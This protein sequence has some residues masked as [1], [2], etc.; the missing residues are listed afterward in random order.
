MGE[1]DEESDAGNE[2]DD[3]QSN[4][5]DESEQADL[6]ANVPLLRYRVLKLIEQS[7]NQIH[8]YNN[9]I[10]SAVSFC[11]GFSMYLTVNSI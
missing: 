5:G 3:F 11:L 1:K 6:V 10:V 4:N 9:M 7:T 2:N 8:Q